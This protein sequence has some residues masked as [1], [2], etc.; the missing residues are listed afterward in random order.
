M[1][2]AI[3]VVLVDD[4]PLVREGV[5]AYLETQEDIEVVGEAGSGEE[6]LEQVAAQ[7][8]D[9]VLMDLIMPGMDG[10]A[11][12]QR[13]RQL[14]PR[15]QVVVLTS[16]HDDANIFPAIKAGAL[17]YLLKDSAPEEVANAVR[18]A[19]RGEA[20]LDPRVATRLMEEVRGGTNPFGELTEREQEVL[21]LVAQGLSNAEIAE[22]LFIAEKTVK[23]HVSNV[24]SKLYLQDRTQ[25]AVFAWREG[26]VRREG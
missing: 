2:N 7:V 13:V 6:A 8:P 3:T 23:S 9:V 1:S 14:S 18:R 22:Q 21:R 26:F 24:L 19:G 25:A 20:V 12:T 5:R 11:A 16:F 10:I 15:T 4:H 17:S